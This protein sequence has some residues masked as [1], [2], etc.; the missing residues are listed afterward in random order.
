MFDILS[1]SHRGTG[2]LLMGLVLVAVV[3]TMVLAL[4]SGEDD[5]I[6]SVAMKI[7]VG[8]VDL[9]VLIGVI[10][11]LKLGVPNT[12]HPVLAILAA[13]SFHAGNKMKHWKRVASFVVG[14]AC[15]IGTYL[16]VVA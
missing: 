1:A 15:V 13:I 10:L 4:R 16:L 3:W 9:Q 8:L 12:W 14:A 7:V 6:S 2:H 5:T 11:Y